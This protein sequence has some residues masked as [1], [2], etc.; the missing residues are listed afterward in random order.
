MPEL[1]EVE[2]IRRDLAL[3]L[4]GH[5]IRAVHILSP[6]TA[7]PS[8]AFLKAHLTGQKITK[9]ERRGKLLIFT[10]A[11]GDFYLLIHLKMTGQLIYLDGKHKIAGGH[12]LRQSG[13]KIGAQ[14]KDR[15]VD[16]VGGELPNKHTR[17]IIELAG[18]RRLFFNDMRKFGYVKLATTAELSVLLKNNYGP[19]PLTAGF[20]WPF[21]QKLLKNR[22]TKIKALLLDQKL[23]AGLG[24][25][26]VDE[27]L[28]EAK[29]D[30]RR[31]AGSLQSGDSRKLWQAINRVIR[32]AI[33]QRGTT[34]SDYVDSQG[35]RGNFSRF[36]KVYGRHGEKCPVCRRLIRKIKVAGRGTHYC[37]H[38]QK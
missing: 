4:P 36:L 11:P 34:F 7:S 25:I 37:A 16:S 18:G 38:C 5:R 2:T 35:R 8:A 9:I 6:K 29:I 22:S 1:P 13:A 24:N 15:F 28:W 14:T 27:T 26:Y 10:L 21:F 33:K 3:G 31:R 19:E 17:V 23:I 32:Q 30:P 20:S 12:S